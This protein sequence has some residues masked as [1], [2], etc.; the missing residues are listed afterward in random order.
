MATKIF[1][2]KRGFCQN[3]DYNIHQRIGVTLL[4]AALVVLLAA[5]QDAQ[6][7]GEY[8][9]PYSAKQVRTMMAYHGA[10][11]AKFDG[12]QWWFLSGDQWIRIEN[13]GASEFALLSSEQP[14][15]R[16]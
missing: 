5:C 15:P 14:I 16:L 12:H 10:L 9:N 6:V 4:L 3:F 2:M 1:F 13:A 11:V 8:H 7:K